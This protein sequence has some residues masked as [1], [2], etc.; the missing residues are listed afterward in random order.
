MQGGRMGS[1]GPSRSFF[2]SL[3]L[4]TDRTTYTKVNGGVEEG[5]GL[6]QP[7]DTSAKRTGRLA[8]PEG[9][10]VNVKDFLFFL[11][12]IGGSRTW[13]NHQVPGAFR[14]PGLFDCDCPTVC[15]VWSG[16]SGIG[17][18]CIEDPYVFVQREDV[19]G[20][21]LLRYGETLDD[22]HR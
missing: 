1:K 22:S 10:V 19:L 20:V 8:P 9:T 18:N 12:C 6:D 15:S 3:S 5:C 2:L 7:V 13:L 11:S 16:T 4:P 17:R 14:Y 21:G